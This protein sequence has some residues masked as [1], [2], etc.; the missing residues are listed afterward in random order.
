MSNINCSGQITTKN[1]QVEESATI[2]GTNLMQKI[3]N[4]ESTISSLS[5]NI[6]N[7]DNEYVSESNVEYIKFSNGVLLCWG[8]VP[9]DGAANKIVNF[10]QPTIDENYIVVWGMQ[11]Q[12]ETS[13]T[14]RGMG[15]WNK[16]TSSFTTR[17]F[18]SA[19]KDWLL[20]GRWKEEEKEGDE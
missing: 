3:A 5:Q 19:A 1:L 17:Q 9:N 14:F 7:L 10:P 2:N 13:Q 6:T 8:E 11:S 12:L 20:I 4:I 16:T 18:N 15:A